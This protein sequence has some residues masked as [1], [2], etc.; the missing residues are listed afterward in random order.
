MDAEEP[1]S[2]WMRPERSG[3]P[4]PGPQRSYSR[5]AITEAAV[6]IA[7]AEGLEAA[8]MRRI[9]AEI[10]AGTMSL[11]NYVPS[12]ED[13][14]E[15]MVDHVVGE[16]TLPKRPGKDWRAG[17][18]LVAH[19]KRALWLRHPWL[20]TLTPGHPIWGPNTL[21]QQEFALATLD[22][23]T[24]SVDEL[25]SLVNLLSGYVESFV[26]NEVG[27]AQEAR[28]TGVGMAEWMRRIGPYADE[29]VA[30]GRYPMFERVMSETTTPY[31]APDDRFQYGLSRVL[32]SVAAVLDKLP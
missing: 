7:D 25:V 8:S 31:L 20:A 22:G 10:G 12:R 1:I 11:Y 16:M 30:S 4:M 28:R 15:L 3:R 14:I 19:Q 27:W 17:M 32:D 29:L 13:L 24:L 6:R 9:A 21:R 5:Q 18:T 23:F 26:R 2:I